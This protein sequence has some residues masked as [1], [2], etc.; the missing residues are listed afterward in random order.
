[1]SKKLSTATFGRVTGLLGLSSIAIVA[2]LLVRETRDYR[3]LQNSPLSRQLL[4]SSSVNEIPDSD[5][6]EQL[7]KL[8][9]EQYVGEIDD[10][11]KFATGA[12]R[13]MVLSLMDSESAFYD[14][15]DARV[16]REARRGNYEGFGCD[17]KFVFPPLPKGVAAKEGEEA[18]QALPRVVVS[19]VVPNGPADAAGIKP[20]DWFETIDG[21]WVQN[22]DLIQRARDI[23]GKI[24]RKEL[25][26]SAMDGFRN[27]IR[28]K[29][30][31]NIT[32]KRAWQKVMTGKSGASKVVVMRNGVPMNFTVVKRPSTRP[33]QVGAIRPTF[34]PDSV[35]TF[36]SKIKGQ[37][38]VT[39]DLRGLA[40]G[41]FKTMNQY[42]GLM[43]K[44]GTYG[45]LQRQGKAA[46]PVRI[47]NNPT[48]PPK[49][50][51][52]LVNEQTAGVP[53]IMATVL[54]ASGATV[55]GTLKQKAMVATEVTNLVDGTTYSLSLGTFAGGAK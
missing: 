2:G 20:G 47:N 50:I 30:Q 10:D 29:M 26:A 36:G 28:E 8:V 6:F 23:Q 54:K 52:V 17:V 31:K 12:V 41:D 37:S 13:G 38:T 40:M 46:V 5:Y 4:V 45:S 3:I 39:L 33:M 42:V 53:A 35:S 1:M 51:I 44:K 21:A 25:P 18:V 16:F 34:L 49:R 14:L 32:A 48:S 22:L 24:E 19:S 27:E 55:T 43:A 11:M 15:E 9:R 7:V